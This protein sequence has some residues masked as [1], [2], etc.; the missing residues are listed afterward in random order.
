MLLTEQI[1]I[2]PSFSSSVA[3]LL[4]PPWSSG[5]A[6]GPPKTADS[7]LP[8]KPKPQRKSPDINSF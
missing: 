7:Q 8:P 6:G 4:K 5:S 3:Q 2:P 1:D